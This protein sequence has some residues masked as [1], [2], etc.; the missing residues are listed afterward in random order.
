MG[1][2][3]VQV[4]LSQLR[5]FTCSLNL[6]SIV[7][8]AGVLAAPKLLNI[9]LLNAPCKEDLEKIYLILENIT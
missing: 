1:S 3:F 5:L 7:H 8:S 2:R 9:I 6:A 4:V